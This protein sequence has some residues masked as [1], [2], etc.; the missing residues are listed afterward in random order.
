MFVGGNNLVNIDVNQTNSW[1]IDVSEKISPKNLHEF[2][3]FQL[4]E[5]GIEKDSK[6]VLFYFYLKECQKYFLAH[7]H[8]FNELFY[9]EPQILKA[10]FQENSLYKKQTIVFILNDYFAIYKNNELIFFKPTKQKVSLEQIGNFVEKSLEQK[11]DAYIEVD[12]KEKIEL[13][14]AFIENYHMFKKLTVLKNNQFKE[15]KNFATVC[16]VSISILIAAFFYQHIKENEKTVEQKFSVYSPKKEL[17]SEKILFFIKNINSFEL[18]MQTMKVINKKV[19]FL[20]RHSSKAKLIEF[21]TLHKGEIKT[22][23]YNT[24]EKIYELNVSFK[25]S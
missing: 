24:Q 25:L 1:L 7:F 13:N 22:L 3:F 23:N 9:I 19:Y 17:I 12:E 14:K 15:L 16:L 21:L 5:K 11:V 2:I 6:S 18:E 4:E 10:Y 8:S 20:L